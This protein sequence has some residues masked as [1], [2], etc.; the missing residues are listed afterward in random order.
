MSVSSVFYSVKEVEKIT[1]KTRMTIYR[2]ERE[3]RLPKLRK[4]G[5]NSVGFLRTEMD[6]WVE[7]LAKA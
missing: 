3:G 5:P 6:Q 1:G 4:L 2:W 7:D